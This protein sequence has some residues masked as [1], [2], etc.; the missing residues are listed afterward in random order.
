[1]TLSKEPPAATPA[2]QR[3]RAKAKN[4]IGERE[5]LIPKR[6]AELREIINA[7]RTVN[8]P[9]K[10]YDQFLLKCLRARKYDLERAA[11]TVKVFIII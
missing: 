5:D 11:K 7:D 10:S 8:A 4:E 6:I 2:L 3:L 1:M 9:P